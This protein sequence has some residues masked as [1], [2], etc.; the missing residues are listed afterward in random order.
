M[1]DKEKLMGR[2]ASERD[3]LDA[4]QR[5][6]VVRGDPTAAAAL[7]KIGELVGFD[8]GEVLMMQNTYDRT[9]YLLLAGK[10][11]LIINGCDLPYG[12]EA[13]DILGEISAINPEI[14]RTATVTATEPVA[15][16]KLEHDRLFDV[17]AEHPEL[18]RM[19]A[20]ELSSK[21]EQR[22]KFIDTTNKVPLV[23]MISSSEALTVAEEI[24]LGIVKTNIA[25]VILWS[26]DEIFPPGSY[27]LEVLRRQVAM[28]DFGIAIAHPDDIRRSRHKQAAVPRDNVIYEL[29]FFTS[30]LGRD[31]VLL[32]VPS[33]DDVE[34][35]S[36]FKGL[37]PL[38][39]SSPNDRVPIATVLA[40]TVRQIVKAIERHKVRSKLEPA[41]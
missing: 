6:K 38:K 36:D 29:G 4:V 2:F 37:T 39:Y 24:R 28:A 3:L 40:P 22:N 8:P 33:D 18:W 23:F 12:R 14:A 35:P 9:A 7:V 26:D 1:S 15:A 41:R 20:V 32:L 27:P 25:D 16:L 31:R 30:V 5:Q 10:V 13:G 19:L 21:L 17:A 34:L 11:S